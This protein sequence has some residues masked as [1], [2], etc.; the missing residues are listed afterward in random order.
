MTVYERRG[1]GANCWLAGTRAVRCVTDPAPC[2]TSTGVWWLY[3]F[4]WALVHLATRSPGSLFAGP[5]APG[6]HLLMAC[7]SGL[8]AAMQAMGK[9]QCRLRGARCVVL[10]KKAGV[11]AGLQEVLALYGLQLLYQLLLLRPELRQGPGHLRLGEEEDI[12][13]RSA[14]RRPSNQRWARTCNA[15]STVERR[16]MRCRMTQRYATATNNDCPLSHARTADEANKNTT[17]TQQYRRA[18]LAAP[19][20]KVHYKVLDSTEAR[21]AGGRRVHCSVF[22]G[23][24]KSRNQGWESSDRHEFLGCTYLQVFRKYFQAAAVKG[25]WSSTGML[26][27]GRVR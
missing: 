19:R 15:R 9:A 21:R 24:T 17:A 25:R 16:K 22:R 7:S 8:H 1:C 3:W 10:G 20:R 5:F 2:G 4:T 14:N 23:F 26:R 12:M 6:L 27:D 11:Q 18:L 13:L